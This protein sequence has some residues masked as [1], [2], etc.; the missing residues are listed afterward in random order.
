MPEQRYFLT[1]KGYAFM[2]SEDFPGSVWKSEGLKSPSTYGILTYLAGGPA[3][4]EEIVDSSEG[5]YDS[6][7]VITEADVKTSLRRLFEAG[8]VDRES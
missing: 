6:G 4:L 3:P 1:D 2:R 5:G 7:V 8:L